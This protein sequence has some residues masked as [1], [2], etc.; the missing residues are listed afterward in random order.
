MRQDAD[1]KAPEAS[2]LPLA[3]HSPA[4]APAC[5]HWGFRGDFCFPSVSFEIFLFPPITLTTKIAD[6]K[7]PRAPKRGAGWLR[8]KGELSS[9]KGS[10]QPAQPRLRRR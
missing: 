4:A 9:K 8:K 3:T 5:L 2:A 1:R 10:V 7:V 6:S